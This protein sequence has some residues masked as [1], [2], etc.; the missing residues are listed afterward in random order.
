M[1]RTG[2]VI[3]TFTLLAGSCATSAVTKENL[4]GFA[5]P[6][7][8][9]VPEATGALVVRASDATT[10]SKSL[11]P[12]ASQTL[13]FVNEKLVEG[14]CADEIVFFN[15]G[16]AALSTGERI[17]FVNDGRI[18]LH[19]RMPLPDRHE[20]PVE[21]VAGLADYELVMAEPAWGSPTILNRGQAYLG[22]FQSELD[23]V[24]ARF[25]LV[26][27]APV[28]GAEILLRSQLPIVSVDYLPAPDGPSG[29][30]GI[31][32]HAGTDKA[33]LYTYDWNHGQLQPL[34][35]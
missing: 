10:T 22:L 28:G 6:S 17:V 1:D 31:V 23:Y 34:A 11:T 12:V 7:L 16:Q 24:V 30:I 5:Q 33:R 35:F 3:L 18:K 2:I 19:P 8:P 32:Q 9:C 4:G 26:D 14:P 25:E 15:V 29:R 20:V 21:G 13:T 27:G